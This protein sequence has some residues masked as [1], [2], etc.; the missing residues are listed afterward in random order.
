MNNIIELIPYTQDLS[1]LYVEDD[2]IVRM[3]TSTLFDDLFDNI[4]IA[5]D[6]DDGLQKYQ[7]WKRDKGSYIDIIITD[8]SMPKLNGDEMSQ[9]ILAINPQQ[10]I[11]AMT[12][13]NESNKLNYLLDLGFKDIINKPI[14][15]ENLIDKLLVIAREIKK[16]L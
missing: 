8:I 7:E 9:K 15:F 6:G 14:V 4:V 13:Y 10:N 5:N 1:L 11:I 12:A 2:A 16:D 3:T